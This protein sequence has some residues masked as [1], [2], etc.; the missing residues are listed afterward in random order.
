MKIRLWLLR[1]G[2]LAPNPEKRFLGQTDLPLAETGLAQARFWARELADHDFDLILASDLERCR[3][4]AQIILE[5]IIKN[6][7]GKQPPLL[8]DPAFRE[9]DLGNWE[10]LSCREVEQKWPGAIAAR[11]RDFAEYCPE[12]GESFAMLDRRVRQA[13][14]RH[15]IC[16]SN[17]LLDRRP[18][19]PHGNNLCK[20]ND[21]RLPKDPVDNVGRPSQARQ[22]GAASNTSHASQTSVL[23]VTHA[24]VIRLLLARY[25]AIPIQEMF[26]LKLQPGLCAC[27]SYHNELQD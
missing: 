11:G 8:F 16:L 14:D 22:T 7:T 4:T 5:S 21:K 13:L 20:H 3:V 27:L 26:C 12:G 19:T 9:I 23:L 1:H 24:G 10:W 6:R 18:G 15:L 2:C 25:M 17:R